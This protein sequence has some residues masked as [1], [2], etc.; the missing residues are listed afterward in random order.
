MPFFLTH[1]RCIRH[2][3]VMTELILL[4]CLWYEYVPILLISYSH[5]YTVMSAEDAAYF[6]RWKGLPSWQTNFSSSYL[7]VICIA[8]GIEYDHQPAPEKIQFI[9]SAK[10][11]F[12]FNVR[13][14]VFSQG[15]WLKSHLNSVHA[16]LPMLYHHPWGSC[17]PS[18]RDNGLSSHLSVLLSSNDLSYLQNSA[19]HVPWREFMR[20]GTWPHDRTNHQAFPV[21]AVWRRNC[22][23]TPVPAA[24]PISHNTIRL[25]CSLGPL[26]VSNMID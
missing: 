16:L 2:V 10:W 4:T 20:S 22:Q 11:Y 9:V 8:Y 6:R 24:E 19:T 23:W 15:L 25:R 21:P 13:R 12:Q 7:H 26:R 1:S 14:A 17:Y 3:K 5:S 18:L